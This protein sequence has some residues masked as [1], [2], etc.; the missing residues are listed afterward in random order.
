MIWTKENNARQDAA[1]YTNSSDY[2]V[3]WNNNP[4]F[5][6]IRNGEMR[7]LYTPTPHSDSK[8]YTTIRYTDDLEAIGIKTDEDLLENFAPTLTWENN[9]WFE[10]IDHNNAECE[11][12]IYD[13]LY[14]AIDKAIN[15]WVT[16]GA[17]KEWR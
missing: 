11:S 1:F 17:D 7:I 9:S 3:V 14:G 10:I 13:T 15:L 8:T 2:E 12:E 5:S 4:R 16:L 6:V